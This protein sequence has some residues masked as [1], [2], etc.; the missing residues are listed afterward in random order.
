MGGP[1]RGVKQEV[2][3]VRLTETEPVDGETKVKMESRRARVTV[4]DR[5]AMVE[6]TTLATEV[7]VGFQK[8]VVEPERPR[9]K[10][11]DDRARGMERRGEAGR[12]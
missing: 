9:A 11:R 4:R 2:S 7:K 8:A 3:V 10:A 12:L 1:M 5:R 6:P